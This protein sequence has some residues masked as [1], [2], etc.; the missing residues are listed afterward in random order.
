MGQMFHDPDAAAKAASGW[1]TVGYVATIGGQTDAE[2]RYVFPARG[3][4]HV[5]LERKFKTERGDRV[6]IWHP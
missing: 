2:P 6:E 5:L 4:G 3:I 1:E